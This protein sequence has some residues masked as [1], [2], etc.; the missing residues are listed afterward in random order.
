[1]LAQLRV[2]AHGWQIAEIH[3]EEGF[4]VFQYQDRPRIEQLAARSRRRLRIVDGESAYLP[5]G[6]GVADPLLVVEEIK[7]L[8][9]PE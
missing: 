8:L 1:M 5:I 2:W 3:L 9:R 4:I 6:K 7:A